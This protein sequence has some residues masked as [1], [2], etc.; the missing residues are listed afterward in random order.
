MVWIEP[1]SSSFYV[2]VPYLSGSCTPGT[3]GHQ[4]RPKIHIQPVPS[5]NT[6]LETKYPVPDKAPPLLA[7]E[8]G[9]PA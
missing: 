2:G 3:V 7:E 6:R 4:L 8:E 1:G 9:P 5:S